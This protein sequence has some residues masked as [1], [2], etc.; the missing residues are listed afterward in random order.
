MQSVQSLNRKQYELASTYGK[1]ALLL[2]KRNE[3]IYNALRTYDILIKIAVESENIHLANEY[4]YEKLY[5]MDEFQV[6]KNI[7]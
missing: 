4:K 7:I 3:M 2:F 6:P 1:E 5:L